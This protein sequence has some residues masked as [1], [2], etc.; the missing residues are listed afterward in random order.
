MRSVGLAAN[1]RG[2]QVSGSFLALAATSFVAALSA[3][4]SSPSSPARGNGGPIGATTGGVTGTGGSGSTTGGSTTVGSGGTTVASTGGSS[5]GGVSN[6][7]GSN[8][9]GTNA[10]GG[11]TAT[12]GG[13]TATTGGA[14]GAAACQMASY[15]FEPKIPTVYVM[16]DRSGSMFDCIST[17]NQVEPSCATQADTS[18]TKLK[19]AT[20]MVISSLQAQV[21][22]GF[23]VKLNGG[24]VP[25]QHLPGKT[26]RS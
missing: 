26:L 9:S 6:T 14:G 25:F 16:V 19:D 18:W 8:A 22:F 5:S 13:A 12:T 20:K 4:C 23:A 11:S 1:C 10:T 21:R 24:L 3:S 2:R 17:T 15:S 7:G